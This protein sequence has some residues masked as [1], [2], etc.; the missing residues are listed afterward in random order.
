MTKLLRV[1]CLQMTSSASVEQNLVFVD[2]QMRMASELGVEL[3]Q[4]PENF[5][6]MPIRRSEQHIETPNCGIVQSF[7][8]SKSKQY[9]IMVIAGSVP[10]Q[11][12]DKE[13]PYARCLVFDHL[14][15]EIAAYNK[16]H[17]FDVDLPDKQNYMESA[18]YLA[19]ELTKIGVIDTPLAKLGLSICYDLRFP[20]M[21]RLLTLQ[22]AEI[23]MVPS[24]FTATTGQAHWSTLLRAR[25]IENQAFVMAAAQVGRHANG[26]ETWGHSMIID[27]WGVVMSEFNETHQPAIE[28]INGLP[29]KV[30]LLIADLDMMKLSELRIKFPALT[31]RRI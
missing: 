21:Y 12:V 29:N 20:E 25:A 23:I 16:I 24:A 7:L 17:L 18:T 27:P 11:E 10:I 2:Q 6:Q 8:K 5:A 1:A 15:V 4:L 19:G 28:S 14:G 13:K 9:R 3:I 30:G 31:H 26:R 22:G